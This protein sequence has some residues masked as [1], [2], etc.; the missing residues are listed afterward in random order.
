MFKDSSLKY[1]PKKSKESFQIKAPERYQ[2][3]FEEEENEKQQD[4]GNDIIIS[5]KMN[6]KG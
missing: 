6:N 1:Y 2:D 4:C 3:L 5:Q